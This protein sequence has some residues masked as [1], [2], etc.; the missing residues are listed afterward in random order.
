MRGRSDIALTIMRALREKE[1]L[2]LHW[3][4][5]SRSKFISTRRIYV[6]KQSPLARGKAFSNNH[7]A[8]EL[9]ILGQNSMSFE[10]RIVKD[11]WTKSANF[12]IIAHL[13]KPSS[14][15]AITREK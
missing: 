13:F 2:Q 12:I 3:L 15:L 4:D 14:L 9:L 1:I 11:I 7:P 8:Y 10:G 5:L 6:K